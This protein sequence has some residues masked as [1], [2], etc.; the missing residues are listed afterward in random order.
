M[1]SSSVSHALGEMALNTPAKLADRSRMRTHA[2]LSSPF[3]PVS[4]YLFFSQEP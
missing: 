3:L 2:P 4:F 1:R